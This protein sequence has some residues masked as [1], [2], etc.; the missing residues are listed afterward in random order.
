LKKACG[1][2]KITGF[3]FGTQIGKANGRTGIKLRLQWNYR[4][5]YG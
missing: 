3:L 5:I 2:K 1:G 4:G